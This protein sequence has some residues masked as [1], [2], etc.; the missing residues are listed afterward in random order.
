MIRVLSVENMRKSDAR[1]I[2]NGVPGRELMYRAGRGVFEAVR[3]KPP[4]AVV[5]GSGLLEIAEL[6]LAGKKR[7]DIRSFL[8]GTPFDGI[9]LV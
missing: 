7:M 2:E 8:N 1:T 6:Q 4:V 5:C 3:W 9:V